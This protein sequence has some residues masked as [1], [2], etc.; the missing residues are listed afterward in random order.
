M[1]LLTSNVVSLVVHV[2]WEYDAPLRLEDI[3]AAIYEITRFDLWSSFFRGKASYLL[4]SRN[5]TYLQIA[6]TIHDRERIF[7]CLARSM[8]YACETSV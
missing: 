2:H 8:K 5:G 1:Q 4:K 7:D 3:R 6:K